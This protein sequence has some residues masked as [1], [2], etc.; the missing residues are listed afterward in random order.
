MKFSLDEII[1]ACKEYL[2]LTGRRVTYEYCLLEGVNDGVEE[3]RELARLLQGMNCHVNLIPYNPVTG[4]DFHTRS[5]KS[6]K[7]FREVLEGAGMQV[8]QRLQRG[9]DIDAACGQLKAKIK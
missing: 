1:N 8:T 4:L 2:E 7:A 3:A 6:V 9:A 5:R